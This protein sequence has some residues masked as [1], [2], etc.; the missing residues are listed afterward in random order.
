MAPGVGLEPTTY[1]LHLILRFPKGVDY[2]IILSFDEDVGRFL[3]LRRSTPP[4]LERGCKRIVSEP[5]PHLWGLASDYLV[6][7]NVG[8]QSTF[9]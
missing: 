2:I 3:R 8:F 5:S 9:A 4:L 6:L 1:W 7:S